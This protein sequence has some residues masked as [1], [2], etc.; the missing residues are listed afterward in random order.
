MKVTITVTY[1]GYFLLLISAFKKV[2]KVIECMFLNK[3]RTLTVSNAV[4]IQR[5]NMYT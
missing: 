4:Y 2:D 3:K 1:C 5:Y